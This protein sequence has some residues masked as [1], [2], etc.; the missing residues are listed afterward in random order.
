MRLF[1]LVVA[2]AVL[3]SCVAAHD[4]FSRLGL[5]RGASDK[6][7]KRAYKKLVRTLHPDA[8]PVEEREAARARFR[9]ITEAYETLSDPAKRAQYETT[10]RRPSTS[11]DD[12]Q[13]LRHNLFNEFDG[14]QLKAP[15]FQA[16]VESTKRKPT[17]VYFWSSNFPDCIDF[18]PPFK[19]LATRLRGTSVTV[20]SFKCDEDPMLCRR[21]G[22][23]SLPTVKM[24][25]SSASV[26]DYDQKI[27]IVALTAFAAR[28]LSFSN[29]IIQSSA[30]AILNITPSAFPALRSYGVGGNFIWE[31]T[32]RSHVGTIDFGLVTLEFGPCFDC[33]T[34]LQ[35]ALE[36]VG[37]VMPELVVRRV[38][39]KKKANADICSDFKR[40]DRAWAM[41]LADR[42]CWFATKKPF[43]FS[44]E[45]CDPLRTVEY[46]GKYANDA[47]VNFIV[48]GR[49]K[50]SA[51][52]INPVKM[53]KLKQ[54]ADAY[55]VLFD[56][57]AELNEPHRV[58]WEL[59]SR[60]VN[61]VHPIQNK[62]GQ[63][64]L[65]G[66]VNC[67][68]FP[69]LCS[70]WNVPRPFVAVYGYGVKVKSTEPIIYRKVMGWQALRESVERDAEPLHLY[71]LGPQNYDAK[72]NGGL[73]KGKNWFVLY[74]AGQWCPPC[75]Q[76]R[77]AWKEAVRLVQNS[78]KSKKLALATVE[79]DQHKALCNS[80][81]IDNYP[82]M[83][84]IGKGRPKVEYN[85]MRDG[86]ELAQWALDQV[87]NRLVSMHPGDLNSRIQRGE[88][89]LVAFSAGQWCPP[90]N[91][92]GPVMKKVADGMSKAVVTSINCDDVGQFCNMFGIDGY[93]TVVLFVKGRRIMYE[94]NRKDASAIIAWA[95]QFL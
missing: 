88:N 84:F 55:A 37:P 63:R 51:R 18:A 45:H 39:C 25:P 76:I 52:K 11:G 95:N 33:D 94:S 83:S 14:V 5:E 85:G 47:I 64:L 16:L 21:I 43:K 81:G 6:D 4:Y 75:N 30:T 19:A 82:T 77:E 1:V 87:D 91:Q 27:E 15:Q 8:V 26:V 36:T 38:N 22:M 78:D 40:K 60:D 54:S 71:V 9:D 46:D 80:L 31:T 53:D 86:H 89:V 73:K 66:A 13:Y 57:S 68:N 35:L 79:C 44:D 32:K 93:P 10:G 92:I 17:I 20:A 90:C 69:T 2:V 56:D 62:K 34:A 74:N 23:G 72:I 61:R 70:R 48:G 29:P 7:V 58:Q 24:F 67:R 65:I 49:L 3:V 28:F 42:R 41:V 12:R 59:L 50:P